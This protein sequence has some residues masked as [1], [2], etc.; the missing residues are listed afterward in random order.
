ME[1]LYHSEKSAYK[2]KQNMLL[3]K[4]MYSKTNKQ[5]RS[6]TYGGLFMVRN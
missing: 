3:L 1:Q 5:K 6:D 4:Q 2:A